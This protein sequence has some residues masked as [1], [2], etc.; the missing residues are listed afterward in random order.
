MTREERAAKREQ[1]LKDQLEATRRELAQVEAQ[2]RAAARATRAK[3]RQR[4]GTLA[5]EAGLF[6]WDDPTLLG[7]FRVLVRLQ[8][9]RDP[10]AVLDS[11][12]TTWQYTGEVV[13]PTAAAAGPFRLASFPSD[14][15]EVS[16]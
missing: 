6:G 3:R 12:L 14:A 16:R 7:L 5:D 4:V 1:R 11:L 13:T 15:L 9:L 8:D 10:V 2:N